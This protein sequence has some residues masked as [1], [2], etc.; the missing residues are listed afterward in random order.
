MDEKTKVS[1]SLY[2][3]ASLVVVPE[4]KKAVESLSG[5]GMPQK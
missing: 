4:D 1:S 3:I 2:E 5:G